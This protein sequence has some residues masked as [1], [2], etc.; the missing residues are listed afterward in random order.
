MEK[1]SSIKNIAGALIT[2]HVKVEK[3]KK[4]S[5]NPFFKSKYA[6]LSNILDA[7]NDP[8]NEAGLTFTQFPDGEHSLTSLLLHAASG[9]YIQGTFT[10]KPV[11]DDPQGQGSAITYARRYA[12]SAILGLNIEDD[13][14]ANTATHGGKTPEQATDNNKPWLNEKSKEFEGAVEK[15]RVGKSSITALRNFFKIS[16]AVEAKL[17]EQS[18]LNGTIHE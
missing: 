5:T 11:K 2:F 15:M 14:D 18:Q 3:I 6:S 1:S 4:D 9:E 13:D 16:K 10:M 7:I 17:I 12:L 8:L